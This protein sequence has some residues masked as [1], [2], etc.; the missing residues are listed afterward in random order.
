MIPELLVMN[1]IKYD[2]RK[3]K[4]KDPSPLNIQ[5]YKAYRNNYN[6]EIKKAKKLYTCNRITEAGNN[7]RLVWDILRE[8][9]NLNLKR[10]Q[11]GDIIYNDQIITNDNI[12]TEIFSNVKNKLYKGPTPTSKEF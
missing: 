3:V 6:K 8:A 12:L 9:S 10:K 2:L 11:I 5:N 4:P 7:T 1:T